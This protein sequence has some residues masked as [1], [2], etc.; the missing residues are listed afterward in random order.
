MNI[1]NQVLDALKKILL[2]ILTCLLSDLLFS[3]EVA[4]P[5]IN[6]IIDVHGYYGFV[7]AHH[8]S[9]QH[10]TNSHFPGFEVCIASQTNGKQL[11][12]YLYRFPQKG[13]GVFYSPLGGSKMLGNVVAVYPYL[14]FNLTHGRKINL[15]F[16]FACGLGY[17]TKRFDAATNYKNIAIGSHVNAFLQIMYEMRWSFSKRLML[18]AGIE[19]S[20][21]SNGA[22]KTPNLGINIPTVNVGL[23]YKLHKEPVEIIMNEIP[24]YNKR[25]QYTVM[26][27]FGVSELYPANGKK[28]TAYILTGYFMKPLGLKR[29][30]GA[31]VDVFYD[32]AI[33]EVMRR[34]D[35]IIGNKFETIKAGV[36]FVYEMNFSHLSF[37]AQIGGY[38]IAKDK[39]DGYVFDRV[40]LNYTFKKHYV[41]QLGLKT[42]LTTADMVEVGFGYKF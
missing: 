9:M 6:P 32:N 11:W 10:L 4:T 1:K 24:A 17:L 39:S 2:I 40:A 7:V 28:Y 13:I 33:A 15:Y 37:V 19:M 18:M 35:I 14:N 20:H 38:L 22:F 29:K 42:H 31:A 25:W 41:V 30:I 23:S 34:N 16:R 27:H 3:Q 36:S 26:G 21:L 5:S 12:E 8:K